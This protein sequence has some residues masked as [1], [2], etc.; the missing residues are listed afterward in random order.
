MGWSP[1]ALAL[2]FMAVSA[3]VVLGAERAWI[4]PPSD[5]TAPW[6]DEAP[7]RRPRVALVTTEVEAGNRVDRNSAMYQRL[8]RLIIE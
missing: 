3:S 4:D 2:A 1:R 6:P 5:V 8:W 7:R